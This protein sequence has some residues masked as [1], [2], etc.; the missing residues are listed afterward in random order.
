MVIYKINK[1]L[2]SCYI[3]WKISHND[4]WFDQDDNSNDAGHLI[5]FTGTTECCTNGQ[6]SE[7]NVEHREKSDD[8]EN[9]SN[10]GELNPTLSGEATDVD[11]NT[12]N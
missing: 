3:T 6:N 7:E 12:Y 5:R 8:V 11:R 10:A 4:D 2:C 1:G 9:Q